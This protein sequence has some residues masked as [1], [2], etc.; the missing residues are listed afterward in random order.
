MDIPTAELIGVKRLA[1]AASARD[2]GI[3]L[4]S[5]HF[6]RCDATRQKT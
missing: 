5:A 6:T 1:A 3:G 4:A 2:V